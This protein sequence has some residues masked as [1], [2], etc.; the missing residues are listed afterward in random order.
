MRTLF[1]FLSVFVTNVWGMPAQLTFWHS[2]TGEKGKLLGELTQ[3]FNRSPQNGGKYEVVPQFVGTYEEGL[4]KLRT[5][6]LAQQGPHIAQITDIGTQVMIDSQGVVPLQDFIDRD[7]DFPLKDLLTPIKR[8]YEVDGRLCSLPFATS[9]PIL[10]YN[11]DSFEKVGLKGPPQ[12]FGELKEWARRLTDPKKK[13]VGITWPLSSWFFEEFIA[14]QGQVIL[15]QEN[16][17]K[18]RAT[19][20]LYTTPEAVR[21]VTLWA[22]LVKEQTFSNVGRGW[23]PAEANFL[24]GRA[25]MLIHSTSDVFEVTRKANFRVGT[26]PLPKADGSKVGGTVVGGNSLWIMKQKPPNEV[27]GSYLFVKFM[28]SKGV[29]KKWHVGTG[30]FPI[31]EDLILELEKEGFYKKYPAAKT[32]IDQLKASA[33]TPATQGALMGVFAEARDQIESAIERVLARRMTVEE[34]LKRAKLQTDDSLRRYNRFLE[35]LK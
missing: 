12:T 8:Y 14:L 10:Y 26:A 33:M 20:A 31:R 21:F 19:E 24:A 28:A 16:G 30:Y 5:S 22:D 32:A 9:N 29:Q 2:M 27:Q 18:G 17:R 35:K 25:A 23:D 7:P 3:E 34:A 6:L 15:N 13:N 1:F 4:N 11:I